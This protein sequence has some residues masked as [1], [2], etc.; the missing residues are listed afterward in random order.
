M[1][2]NS[3]AVEWKSLCTA[4]HCACLTPFTYSAEKVTRIAVF[5]PNA[6]G[7]FFHHRLVDFSFSD[8]LLEVWKCVLR[9]LHARQS[10]L[11]AGPFEQTNGAGVQD[12][13]FQND[14]LVVRR[15][16]S[17]TIVDGGVKLRAFFDP[18]EVR[19]VDRF[20]AL[21]TNRRV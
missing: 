1:E 20:L 16:R 9:T 17:I 19:D 13:L 8:S 14:G 11:V 5:R 7:W 18:S 12:V 3:V 15:T 10:R 2:A 21:V 6:P 4:Q